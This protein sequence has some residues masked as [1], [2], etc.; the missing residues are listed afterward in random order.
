M[1]LSRRISRGG[2]Q[3][4]EID[5]SIVIRSVDPGVPHE[6]VGTANKMGGWGSRITNQHWESLEA[7]VTFAIDIPKREMTRRREVF[8]KVI[9]WA[10]GAGWLRTNQLDGRRLWVDKVVVPGGGDMWNWLGEYT[11]TFRATS[12]PFWQDENAVEAVKKKISSGS[13]QI[14]IGGTAPG[15]LD[16]SFENVSGAQNT[17]VKFTVDGK[18]LDLHGVNLAANETLNLTHTNDGTLRVRAGS[19]NVYSLLRGA[20]DAY[21]EAGTTVTVGVTATRAGNLTV[22]NVARWL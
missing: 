12:V 22:K 7:S 2:I 17:N 10:K 8:D 1:I 15:V 6:S 19:R 18:E 21:V 9:V 13:V 16:L 5:E 4:D 20:D 14:E 11:I 3:L